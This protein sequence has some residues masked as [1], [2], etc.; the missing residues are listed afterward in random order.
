[1]HFQYIS[2][3][4]LF[5][6]ITFTQQQLHLRSNLHC[7]PNR[8][9]VWSIM[10]NRKDLKPAILQFS[11]TNRSATGGFIGNGGFIG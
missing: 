9:T 1:M 2:R 5:F 3:N 6:S 11:I 7:V 10:F 4:L 8:F